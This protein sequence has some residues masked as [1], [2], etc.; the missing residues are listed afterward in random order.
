MS[1]PPES[2]ECAGHGSGGDGDGR[3]PEKQN[4]SYRE[5]GSVVYNCSASF[6]QTRRNFK[7]CCTVSICFSK[8]RGK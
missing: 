6:L 5:L 8:M 4:V 2:G 3:G 7:E 1:H